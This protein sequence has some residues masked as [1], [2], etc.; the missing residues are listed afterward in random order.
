MQHVHPCRQCW[1]HAAVCTTL[2]SL[3]CSTGAH[4]PDAGAVE[5]DQV[6]LHG[7]RAGDCGHRGV[8]SHAGAE[9]GPSSFRLNTHPA[10]CAVHGELCLQNWF[11]IPEMAARLRLSTWCMALVRTRSHSIA[12][13]DLVHGTARLTAC[14]NH[15]RFETTGSEQELCCHLQVLASVDRVNWWHIFNFTLDIPAEDRAN[16]PGKVRGPGM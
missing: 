8:N 12:P 13:C 5:H 16:V 6:H 11:S 14:L 10:D 1:M 15:A 7:F 9:V 2:H 3:K 4:E